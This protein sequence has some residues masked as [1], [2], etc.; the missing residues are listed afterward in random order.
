MY[1]N[2]LKQVLTATKPYEQIA[3]SI[4]SLKTNYAQMKIL[5]KKSKRNLIYAF[6]SVLL[7]MLICS[8]S[9][10]EEVGNF[11]E[12]MA[13][14]KSKG[15]WGYIDKKWK[16]YLPVKEA[17]LPI[18]DSANDFY[19][20][21]AKVELNSKY[22]YIDKKGQEVVPLKYDSIG[23][24]SEGFAMVKV[25]LVRFNSINNQYGY[26]DKTGNEILPPIY[27]LIGDFSEDMAVVKNGKK[28]GYIDKARNVVI[29]VKY[30]F[31]GPFTNGKAFVSNINGDLRRSI[32]NK[33][34]EEFLQYDFY[35]RFN[36]MYLMKSGNNI[37]LMNK[38]YDII[39]VLKIND[40]LNSSVKSGSFHIESPYLIIMYNYNYFST[41][42]RN[43]SDDPKTLIISF[44][45]RYS[46]Y[47]E[48]FVENDGEGRW[49]ITSFGTTLIYYDMEK[50]EIIGYD[51]L[52]GR[53]IPKN[54]TRRPDA[55]NGNYEAWYPEYEEITEKI[56]THLTTETN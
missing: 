45:N 42:G 34:G 3:D 54:I 32:I 21:I 25:K 30:D 55:Y 19:E 56:K 24:F 27:D 44:V 36:E 13:K 12:N 11:N 39:S 33:N 14:V 52:K 49:Y 5:F 17:I 35:E 26:V 47:V 31:A 23:D 16:K 15:K 7:F 22:G 6:K 50:K 28:I 46:D 2:N 37:L 40:F 48:N 18:Y 1:I 38:T 10:Y 51:F 8:C 41:I 53:S 29:S 20:G 43:S 9:R 4:I